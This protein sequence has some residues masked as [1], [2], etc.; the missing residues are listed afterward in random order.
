VSESQQYSGNESSDLPLANVG[1][2]STSG[3][4]WQT[5]LYGHGTRLWWLTAACLAV[6]IAITVASL[7][8]HGPTITIHFDQGHGLKPG[9]ALKHLGI[10]IGE[11][12][13]VRLRHD[14]AGVRVEVQLQP[15]AAGIARKGSQFWVAR[16]QVS[17]SRVSNLET[18]VGAKYLGVL[19]G[20]RD[21][22]P[23]NV[24]QGTETPLTL[25]DTDSREITIRFSQGYS[26]AAGDP[27]R[28]R[29][30]NVGEVVE[31]RLHDDLKSVDVLARLSGNAKRLAR[32][33]SQF[34]VERPLVGV[35]EVRGL[36]TIVGGRYLAVLPG[37]TGGEP[38][39]EFVG[40]DIAPAGELAEGGLRILLEEDRQA[41]LVRGAPILYRGSRVGKILSVGL[42]TDAATVQA[43]AFIEPDYVDL[44]RSDTKFWAKSGFDVSLGFTGITL[45]AD[46]LAAIALGGIELATPDPPGRRV[47]T[48][49]RFTVAPEVDDDWLDW[50]P[51][52]TIGAAALPERKALPAP[53]AASLRW[54]TSQ[55]GFT[56]DRQHQGWVLPVEGNRLLGPT[57]LFRPRAEALDKTQLSAA[58]N[59]Y[60]VTANMIEAGGAISYL[61]L[62]VDAANSSA[63]SFWPKSYLRQA[64]KPEDCLV[65]AGTASDRF[66]ID[67]TRFL[68]KDDRWR[69]D[70]S[71][72]LDA[73]L[74]GASVVAQSDGKVIGL[75]ILGDEPFVALLGSE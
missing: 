51:R 73:S 7:P 43:W 30:M 57:D 39:A 35:T 22:P 33:G 2:S 15:D 18:V 16:P 1:G 75:L 21:A 55:L 61:Q 62:P 31:V 23:A 3:S 17:L 47:T 63:D 25:L 48:G 14:S 46:S 29:G 20:P 19:P 56:R 6:A 66:P 68:A 41:G 54:Q 44:I 27:I 13:A 8:A 49:H 71:L 69:I 36:D 50:R 34:W 10:E 52:I 67:S 65:V 24:F 45:D 38:R 58:G 53:I 4:P 5:R 64:V 11:V 59:T 60:T 42:A 70:P 26:L 32:S 9:D 37:P 74:H 40:Q 12:T 28:F 72:S